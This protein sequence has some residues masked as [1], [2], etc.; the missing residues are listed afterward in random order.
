M[1]R[2]SLE[3]SG[4][5]DERVSAIARQLGV[6]KIE[7]VRRALAAYSTLDREARNKDG[8]IVIA[9][10]SVVNPAVQTKMVI[11]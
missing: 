4:N 11:P 9:F 6:T 2:M 8:E 10:S 5:A 7:V 1:P 3:L